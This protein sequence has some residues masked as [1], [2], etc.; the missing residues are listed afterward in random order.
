MPFVELETTSQ[1]NYVV[2]WKFIKMV[3]KESE[4]MCITLNLDKYRL[5]N[6]Y[7]KRKKRLEL[8]EQNFLK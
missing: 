6:T 8:V 3:K 5:Y 7:K 4:F 2:A 1:S